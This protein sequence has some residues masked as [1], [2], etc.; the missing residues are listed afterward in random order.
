MH[1]HGV[2]E[3]ARIGC[4]HR[5]VGDDGAVRTDRQRRRQVPDVNAVFDGSSRSP[6][7]VSCTDACDRSG[8]S[9]DDVL[10]M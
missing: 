2:D 10:V 1:G 8:A 6:V 7:R 3:R 4:Q 5:P 9:A